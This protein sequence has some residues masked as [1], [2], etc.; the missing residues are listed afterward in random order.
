MSFRTVQESPLNITEN[1]A[2]GKDYKGDGAT[3]SSYGLP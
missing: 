1:M 2:T 3:S